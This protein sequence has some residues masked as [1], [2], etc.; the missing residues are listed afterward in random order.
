MFK[1]IIAVASFTLLTVAAVSSAHAGR[2]SGSGGVNGI[3]LNGLSINGMGLNALT[4]NGMSL[5]GTA[6]NSFLPN[7]VHLNGAA[8]AA[9]SFAID[10]IELPAQAR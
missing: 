9:S 3:S 6:S 8:P 1:S 4:A 10:G 7:G 5:N 2:M